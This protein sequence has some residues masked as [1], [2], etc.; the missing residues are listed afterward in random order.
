MQWIIHNLPLD[1]GC[2]CI[3]KTGI[4]KLKNSEHGDRQIFT[5][6]KIIFHPRTDAPGAGGSGAGSGRNGKS[7]IV[8]SFM[9]A[10]AR[11]GA[12]RRG[13]EPAGCPFFSCWLLLLSKPFFCAATLRL[14]IL[15]AIFNRLI[16][17]YETI[18]NSPLDQSWRAK[19]I[20][21][22]V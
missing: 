21:Q 19:R 14:R 3:P 16:M 1:S 7:S 22:K 18:R 8:N 17:K 15:S 2:S 13:S 4:R 6:F 20:S 5:D 10:L 12:A 9:G 11:L